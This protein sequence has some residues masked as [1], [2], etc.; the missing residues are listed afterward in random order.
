MAGVKLECQDQ[1]L[2]FAVPGSVRR[3]HVAPD[4]RSATGERIQQTRDADKQDGLSGAGT[5]DES[6]RD[7]VGI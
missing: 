7:G 4:D 1:E 3:A 5:D 6:G 2:F